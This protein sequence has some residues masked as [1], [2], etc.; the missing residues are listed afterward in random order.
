MPRGAGEQ[1]A[2]GE[3]ELFATGLE[4]SRSDLLVQ[5]HSRAWHNDN[6]NGNVFAGIR[7]IFHGGLRADGELAFDLGQLI[8]QELNGVHVLAPCD[9]KSERRVID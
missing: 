9:F 2:P 6:A 4:K 5:A 7:T 8:N 1:A 3:T